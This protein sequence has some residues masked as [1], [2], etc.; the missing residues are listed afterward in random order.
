MDLM[1]MATDL[2]LQKLGSSAGSL[3]SDVVASA[4]SALLGG[5]NGQ[6]DLGALVAKFSQGDL[7]SLAQS[8]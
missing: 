5:E 6:L 2:F 1:K 4:L 3:N 7:A 8:G